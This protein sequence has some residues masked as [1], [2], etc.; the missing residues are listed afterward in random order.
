MGVYCRIKS[1]KKENKTFTFFCVEKRIFG[2]Y[3][4]LIFFGPFYSFI[5]CK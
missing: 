4:Y 3:I 2:V 1:V 5:Y